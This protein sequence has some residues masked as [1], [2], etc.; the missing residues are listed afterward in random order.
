MPTEM[1]W[2]PQLSCDTNQL[3]TPHCL[4]MQLEAS[5]ERI[6]GLERAE[7]TS[8]ESQMARLLSL[9]TLM[10]FVCLI[11]AGKWMQVVFSIVAQM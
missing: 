10:D 1:N 11:Y 4:Q 7:S 3:P 8:K 9:W 5:E 6:E 2:E